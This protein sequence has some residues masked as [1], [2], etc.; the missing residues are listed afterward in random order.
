MIRTV[1][2]LGLM[3]LTLTF[4]LDLDAQWMSFKKTYAKDYQQTEELVRK[5]IFKENVAHVQKHNL[6]ADMGMHTYW[7][8]I[9]EYT[10]WSHEEFVNYMNGINL[11]QNRTRTGG[12]T[13]QEPQY[14]V[15]PDTVDWRPKGFVTDVKNQ[16]QCGSCWA[17]SATG[18]LEGQHFKVKGKLVSLSEQNL[19]DCSKAE[20]NFGCHGGLSSNAFDYVRMNAGIDTEDC[21]PYEAK[22]RDWLEGERMMCAASNRPA[23]VPF[24]WGIRTSPMGTKQPSRWQSR[25]SDQ[26]RSRLT[27][28][29]SH[30]SCTKLVSTTNL[31]AALLIWITVS[32]RLGTVL[33]RDNPIG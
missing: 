25:R 11:N 17:F 13:F 20:G 22:V 21:Y 32:S 29:I 5:I 14:L 4:A 16:K 2:F 31:T 19:V 15:L 6:Q 7:L 23:L 9:N 1:L 30:S 33:T 24:V 10:D 18:A 12:S 8:G 26:S 27:R 28:V 3:T